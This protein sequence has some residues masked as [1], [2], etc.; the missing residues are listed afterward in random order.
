MPCNEHNLLCVS[1]RSTTG[2]AATLD[3]SKTS[4]GA[5]SQPGGGW[6]APPSL[7][8]RLEAVWKKLRMPANQKLDAALKY[9]SDQ[10]LPVLAEVEHKFGEC[11]K[12]V[13]CLMD[14]LARSSFD[15]LLDC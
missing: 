11:F 5:S 6:S 10:C 8:S 12:R 4:R 14:I 1:P 9:S 2:G 3:K 13:S 7:Q 15:L